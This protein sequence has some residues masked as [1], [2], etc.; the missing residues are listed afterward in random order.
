LVGIVL[1]AS[2]FCSWHDVAAA[3]VK[4]PKRES[5]HPATI[6]CL[7]P[8]EARAVHQKTSDRKIL[9]C[10][11]QTADSTGDDQWQAQFRAC[12]SASGVIRAAGCEY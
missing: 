6:L 2:A 1:A 11:L 4:T 5:Q 7:G 3:R 10:L 12:L 9:D 8:V